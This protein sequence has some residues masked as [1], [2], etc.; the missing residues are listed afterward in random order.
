MLVD[1]VLYAPSA[2]CETV[3]LETCVGA[4]EA[5]DLANVRLTKRPGAKAAGGL[6]RSR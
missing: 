1:G 3:P 6:T 5:G 2:K 4:C